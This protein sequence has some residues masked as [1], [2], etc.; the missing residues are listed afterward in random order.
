MN[1]LKEILGSISIEIWIAAMVIWIPLALLSY[2]LLELIKSNKVTPNTFK[3]KYWVNANLF[4][5]LFGYILSLIILRLGDYAFFI[6]NKLGYELG[7]TE[8]FVAWLIPL[9]WFIQ[10]QLEKYRKPA[11]IKDLRKEMDN[12]NNVL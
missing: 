5:I 11:I 8:D 6:A 7:K 4:V 10:W 3:I 12:I 1:L 2:K 9:T